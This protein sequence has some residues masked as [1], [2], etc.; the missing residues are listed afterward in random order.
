[1]ETRQGDAS[2]S[3]TGARKEQVRS[4]YEALWD[5]RGLDAMPSILH[6]DFAFRGSLGNQERGHQ[7]FAEYVEMVRS[8]LGGYRCTI[9]ELVEEGHKVFARMS[10][11][12][13]HRKLFLGFE[14][15]GKIVRW[16]G[17][18]LFTFRGDEVAEL[19]VLGDLKGLE[20]QLERNRI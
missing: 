7:E 3:R 4:F 2:P 6:A 8:A 17:C 16:S 14:P 10:F 9:E 13:V 1:M 19:W 5:A 15:T 12:G 18:A 20:E 11:G